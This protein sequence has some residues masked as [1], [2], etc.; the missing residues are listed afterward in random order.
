M[1]FAKRCSEWVVA[2]A[3]SVNIG[4]ADAIAPLIAVTAQCE[5]TEY[6]RFRANSAHGAHSHP[7][8]MA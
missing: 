7:P 2:Q 3:A 5:N 1:P 6:G 4:T 8:L